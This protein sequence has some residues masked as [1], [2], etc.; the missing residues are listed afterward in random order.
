MAKISI[1]GI[2][3]A[4]L[5]AALYNNAAPMDMGFLQARFGQMT[6][7]DALKLMETGD[8]TA[9]MFPGSG[10]PMY[11]DYVYGRPLKVNLSGE[12]FDTA[13]YDRDWGKGSAERIVESLRT[14]R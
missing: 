9:R 13:L 14:K 8:D 3:K 12:E 11:F 5:L 10:R 6:R 2:D 4:E 7:D 1:E